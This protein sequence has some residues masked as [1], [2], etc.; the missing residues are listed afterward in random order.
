MK[1]LNELYPDAWDDDLYPQK[2]QWRVDAERRAYK[3][4]Y[5]QAVTDLNAENEKL[6]EALREAYDLIVASTEY[7]VEIP[8]YR[9]GLL[10]INELL[11]PNN[12]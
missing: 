6:R 7:E 8:R 9:E 12:Q 1:D 3:A 5:T 10:K 2:L 11:K 4:G